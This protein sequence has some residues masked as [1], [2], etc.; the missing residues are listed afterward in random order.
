LSKA[1]HKSILRVSRRL[2]TIRIPITPVAHRQELVSSWLERTAI[3]YG[4]ALE[5]LIMPILVSDLHKS[6]DLDSD[7]AMRFELSRYT[8]I[9]VDQIPASVPSNQGL[10][11]PPQARACFCADCWDDDAR[12]GKQPFVRDIWTYWCT[13]HCETHQRFLSTIRPH[14]DKRCGWVSWERTWQTR[15]NWVS[16]FQTW[17]RASGEQG[18]WWTPNG[19][20]WP[21][22][23][24]GLSRR[25]ISVRKP[26]GQQLALIERQ[27]ESL[28]PNVARAVMRA[29]MVTT[30]SDFGTISYGV[31]LGLE[32]RIEL[33]LA[34]RDLE[35]SPISTH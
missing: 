25:L 28:C 20:K 31:P 22:W 27:F 17:R 24:A 35:R 14:P 30:E 9:P 15:P 6:L 4:C 21:T 12:A 29:G 8:G 23:S 13:V 19:R 11:L 7:P 18:V 33:I 5:Q 32:A 34:I 3:F 2:I 26:K 10:L 1:K 16:A